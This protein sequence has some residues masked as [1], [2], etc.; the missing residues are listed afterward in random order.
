MAA[1][2]DGVPTSLSRICISS[3]VKARV[4]AASGHARLI[5]VSQKIRQP[6]IQNVARRL[7]KRSA[8]RSLERS[9]WQ[10]DFR[11]LW[12]VSIFQRNVY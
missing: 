2:C 3:V 12:K 1:R 7:T 5:I 4:G 8:V 9:A 10:P 6:R 11:I